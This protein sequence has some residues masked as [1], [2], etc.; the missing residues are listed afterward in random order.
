M[1]SDFCNENKNQ[2]DPFLDLMLDSVNEEIKKLLIAYVIRSSK[3]W[4]SL[5]KKS[6]IVKSYSPD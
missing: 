6:Q 1:D 3:G 5:M 4:S 2:N